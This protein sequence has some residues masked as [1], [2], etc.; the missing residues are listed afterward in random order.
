MGAQIELI[1]E[2]LLAVVFPYD[3]Q[4]VSSIKRLQNR[5]WNAKKGR[6]EVHLSELAEVMKIFGLAPHDL[7][8][9]ILDVYRRGWIRC[10]LK[11]RIGPLQGRLAGTGAPL[12]EIDQETSFFVPGHAFSEKFQA[13]QWDGKRH[14]FSLRTQS[15]PSGL[16]PRVRRVL[17]RHG[18]EYALEESPAQPERGAEGLKAQPERTALR[19]Y[20]QSALEAA[21]RTRRGIIQIA[22]GGGKTLLAAHLIR[23]IGRPT[24][25]FVHTL[26]LLYQSAR[27]FREE[28]GL[29]VGLLGDGQACLR[30]LTVATI[31]T[32]MRAFGASAPVRRPKAKPGT[33]LDEEE[34]QERLEQ[35]TNLD[36]ATC[37]EVREAIQAAGVVI[38]DECHHVP[39][40]SFYKIAMHTGAADWRFGLSATPWRDDGHDLLL[41]AALGEK[42]S[43]MDCSTL[44]DHGFLVPPRI[45]MLPAPKPGCNFR[46]MRYPECYQRAIVENQERNR[47]IAAQAQA[48]SAQGLSILILVAQIAHGQALQELLPEANFVYGSLDS[49]LRQQ[50]LRELEQK[51]H[52]VMIATTL[53]DEGLD[54]PSLDAV[55]LGG[56]GKSPTRA[57]QRIGR[58]LRPGPGKA[59]A[60]ILDFSDKAPY[61]KEHSQ[62][63][64]ALYRQERRFQIEE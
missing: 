11:A 1:N 24:F 44:I 6:W 42:V 34:E 14:L 38:F 12:T 18:I 33:P 52:P 27:V 15:F 25:F 53:A 31:Q 17:E 13:K 41:E 21:L 10:R 63:R 19:P 7:Q 39:A 46:G 37:Q 20:Q 35:L 3:A 28:L 8:P 49:G 60:F 50:Y 56:G 30:P 51:L 54:I 40:D 57:Y 4:A 61:L 62:A 29:D 45:L 32:V 16:W 58:A 23:R 64:L 26:D 59:E 47:V 36:E 5:R 43:V 55:I 48:W 2:E 22:T 9:K